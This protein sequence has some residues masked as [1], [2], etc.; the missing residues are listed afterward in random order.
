ML[1]RYTLPPTTIVWS[2]FSQRCTAAVNTQNTTKGMERNS[3]F[4]KKNGRDFIA[5]FKAP[6]NN[7][8]IPKNKIRRARKTNASRNAGNRL[9]AE[10][11]NK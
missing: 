1:K 9:V 6:K 11:P 2:S 8:K 5:T 4:S 7:H 3:W 10:A